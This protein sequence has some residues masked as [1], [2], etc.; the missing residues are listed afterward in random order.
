MRGAYQIPK[1]HAWRN[2]AEDT[3]EQWRERVYRQRDGGLLS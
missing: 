1:A 3:F 2:D